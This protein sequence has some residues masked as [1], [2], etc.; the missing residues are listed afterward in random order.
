MRKIMV[1][2]AKGGAGK[3]TIA[4]NLAAYY[5]SRG[6]KVAIADF[7]PQES[8]LEWIA[9][10][11]KHPELPPIYG[12]ASHDQTFRVPRNTE[13][14]IVDVPAAL[15]GSELKK[16][17]RRAETIIVP[18]MPSPIDIRACKHFIE[19]LKN[20]PTIKGKRAKIGVVANRCNGNS[21]I[22]LELDEYLEKIRGGKYLTALR[23]SNNYIRAIGQGMGVHELPGTSNQV[24]IAEWQPLIDWLDSK[25]STP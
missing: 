18:V 5:A 1:L 17:V 12:V 22:F 3:S 10:R 7:D 20:T 23:D 19:E 15:H 13:Y 16:L 21:N 4:T 2:N 6:H 14:L 11:D 8:S 9:E 25:R 24:D